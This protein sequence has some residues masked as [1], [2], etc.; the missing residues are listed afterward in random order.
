MTSTER[1]KAFIS[2]K[3][4]R[5]ALIILPL[6][7]AA[8]QAHAGVIFTLGSGSNPMQASGNATTNVTTPFSSSQILDGVN[9]ISLFGAATYTANSSGLGSS[10]GSC[11]NICG[12]FF[13]F[14]G[15][16]GSFASDTLVT[17]YDFTVS[18]SNGNPLQW[19]LE[20]FINDSFSN[21]TSGSAANGSEVTGSLNITGLN[22]VALTS[23]DAELEVD[24]GGASFAQGDTLTVTI[25]GGASVDIGAATPE[26]G[27]GSLMA[28]A[29]AALAGFG[30]IRR[31][32]S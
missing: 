14:G 7:A 27:T 4:K 23:W 13:T 28:I 26:P 31:R 21:S 9:G 20:V 3:L 17:N 5:T 18:D 15:G 1:A 32:L 25:P 2:N 6:A 22:G 8:V 16:S 11:A 29:A 24:F 10:G 12:G 19:F 30:A